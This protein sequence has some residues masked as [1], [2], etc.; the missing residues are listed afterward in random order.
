MHKIIEE[1][2]AD[3]EQFSL[4]QLKMLEDNFSYLLVQN[5]VCF[6]I[7]PSDAQKVEIAMEEIPCSLEAI[8]VT[9]FHK[10]HALGAAALKGDTKIPILG[11][12][13]K[14]LSFIDSEVD[15]GD[16]I[17]LGPFSME[18]I[19]APGHTFEHVMYF[20]REL[21]LLFCGDVIFLGGLGKMEEGTEQQYFYTIEKI[22]ALPKD[23]RILPGKDLSKKNAEFNLFLDPN[24]KWAEEL[25]SQSF[26]TIEMEMKRNPFL[27]AK[28]P[29][30]FKEVYEKMEAFKLS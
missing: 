13:H 30:K 11:P 12:K 19:H 6:A 14:S 7:D 5:G 3:K 20:F 27:M 16:A 8:L 21:K 24:F 28:T 18:V 1:I 2:N 22:K 26:A 10:S 15:D 4:Y 25:S 29:H 9:H 17:S 23:T